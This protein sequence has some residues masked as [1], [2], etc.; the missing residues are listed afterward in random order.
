MNAPGMTKAA[1]ACLRR[2][3]VISNRGRDRR[4]AHGPG[5]IRPLPR[6]PCGLEFRNPAG[7]EG[8]APFR[9][10]N[11]DVPSSKNL[12]WK[13]ATPS[14][15]GPL[16]SGPLSRAGRPRSQG[17]KRA[18][19]SRP[20]R[21]RSAGWMKVPPNSGAGIT[22]SKYTSSVAFLANTTADSQSFSTPARTFSTV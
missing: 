18:V 10:G 14:C 7:Q 15:P 21:R 22:S 19:S 17:Q 3:A 16:K 8:V 9:P 12:G 2:Q 1:R 13:G 4:M 20:T 5:C 11:E 6:R